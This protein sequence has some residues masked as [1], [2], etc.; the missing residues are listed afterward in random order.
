MLDEHRT[1]VG[2]HSRTLLCSLDIHFSWTFPIR[3][4]AILA[5]IYSTF[6]LRVSLERRRK[7]FNYHPLFKVARRK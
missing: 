1:S 6:M 7:I 5:N 3:K 2:A 4:E